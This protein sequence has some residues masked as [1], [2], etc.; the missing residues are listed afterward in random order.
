MGKKTIIFSILLLFLGGAAIP[1][2]LLVNNYIGT[3]I[4]DNVDR[5]LL[6]IEDQFIPTAEEMILDMGP[7]IALQMIQEHSLPEIEDMIRELGPAMAL[8]KIRE[9]ALTLVEEEIYKIGPAIALQLIKK[10]SVSANRLMVHASFLAQLLYQAYE[11]GKTH[12]MDM[13]GYHVDGG[14]A[15]LNLFFDYNDLFLGAPLFGG[16]GTT[17]FSKQLRANG[18]PPILGISEWWSDLH[19]SDIDL[20]IGVCN[21]ALLGQIP[22]PNPNDILAW[23]DPSQKDTDLWLYCPPGIIQHTTK[24]FGVLDYLSNFT[25]ANKTGLHSEFLAQYYEGRTL[26][27]AD[28]EILARYF[29]E[30]WVPIAMPTLLTQLQNPNSEFS[31]RATEY[32]GMSLDDIAYHEFLK[33]WINFS[34]YPLGV[35]FHDFID[36]LPLGTYGLEV[37]SNISVNSAYELWDESNQWSFLNLTGILKW[38]DANS[39]DTSKSDLAI[40]FGLT[41]Q[42]VAYICNWLWGIDGFSNRLFPMLVGAPKPYGYNVSMEELSQNVFYELWANGTALGLVLYPNGL[43]FGEFFPEEFEI[44]TTGFEV[45]I[46]TPTEMPLKLVK[47]LWNNSNQFSL[48]NITGIQ[49]WA[50][51]NTSSIEKEI[52]YNE[53]LSLG[54]TYNQ[55][56]RLF[57]WLW[58]GSTSF[59]QFLLPLLINSSLGYGI[60]LSELSQMV[61]YEQ[62]ANGTVLGMSLFP[63]GL[64]FGEFM[65]NLPLGMTGFEVGIPIPTGL[66][67]DQ[68]ERL[69][70]ISSPFSLTNM[71]GIEEWKNAFTNASTKGVLQQYYNLSDTQIQV[72]LN[73]LWNG[74]TSF[75]RCLLP[76]LLE[77]ELGYNMTLTEFAKV[78]LLEQWANGTIMDMNI[79]PGG[80]DF[81]DFVPSIPSGTT[82]FEVGVPIPTNMS[83][84]SALLLWDPSNPYSLVNDIQVWWDVGSKHSATYNMTRDANLLDDSTMDTILQWL[85]SFRDNVMPFLAQVEYNLPID[86]TTLGNTITISMVITGSSIIGIGG[87]LLMRAL[88]KRR[89][90]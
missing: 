24:G 28:F 87:L 36:I 63:D 37:N 81:H 47:A 34:T 53:F 46:P 15:L 76:K 52:I 68:V 26:S 17:S 65:E 79:F 51:A 16:L 7:A 59:S 41:L 29:Y 30:Y 88:L 33:Q 49:L 50:K 22:Q 13:L 35:D 78:L 73:W 80:I 83:L 74:N 38:F 89:K 64:D 39:N 54:I 67:L 85:P 58:N 43:D 19:D 18:L 62:W 57:N 71:A 12:S 8:D 20:E 4:Y 44:N 25:I 61:L 55:I 90:K 9:N 48:T 1:G 21:Y 14:D 72:M 77:S 40:H 66:L 60:G 84:E 86:S 75:S 42:Q 32:I 23:G 27:W 3:L 82:G 31:R 69:W 5:G 2:G 11:E 6:G 70:D 10:I 45:G 56:D